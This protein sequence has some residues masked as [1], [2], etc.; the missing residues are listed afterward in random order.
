MR[1]G[2]IGCG[3]VARKG[4]LPALSKMRNVELYAVSDIDGNTARKIAKKYKVVKS[5]TDYNKLLEQDV[6]DV[7][8][9][10]TPSPTHAQIAVDAANAGKHILVEKPLTYTVKDGQR[11]LDAV[12]RNNV[13]LCVVQN[14]RYFPALRQAK[15]LVSEGRFGRIV[16]IMG[17]AHTPIPLQ[18]TT[19]TWLYESGGVLYDFS[20]HLLDAIC[21]LVDSKITKIS[22][23][24]GDFLG[25]M[26]C[27]NYAQIL[28]EFENLSVCSASVAWLTSWSL[29]MDIHGTAGSANVD[30]RFS[31]LL[32]Y[33][34]FLDPLQEARNSLRKLLN[35]G[36]DAI[37]GSL[38]RG[39]MGF[40]QELIGDFLKSI[41]NNTEP[42][43]TGEEALQVVT[44]LEAAKLGLKENRIVAAKELLNPALAN[45]DV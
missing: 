10:C 16:S 22:A 17:C 30:I 34:G 39:A 14:Y 18:W 6:I 9:I 41:E 37:S 24:G 27:I 1:I 3:A 32:D 11:I 36:R 45:D 44:I 35:S 38:F 21:W 12:S 40:Y 23:F 26:N 2:L 33:Y 31:N 42:P 8:D 4:H 15:Y 20:P 29:H 5:F 13:K 25:N 7:V 43:I 28:M 19:S